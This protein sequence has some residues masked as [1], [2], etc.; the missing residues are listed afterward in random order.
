MMF[1]VNLLQAILHKRCPRCRQGEIFRGTMLRGLL[2]MH[3]RCP[4]CGL[5][6]EREPG[7]FIGA[8]YVS[9]GIAIPP[10]LLLVAALWLFAGWP[11][12]RALL[13]AVLIYLPFVPIVMRL[14]RVIW[15]YI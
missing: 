1:G 10:Y 15:I 9:Y 7:Y 4:V 13:S 3:D 8:M 2:S 12:E 5:R 14:S 6:F 11:Y